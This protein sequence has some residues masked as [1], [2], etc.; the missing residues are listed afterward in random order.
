MPLTT[1]QEKDIR[2]FKGL[3]LFFV[4]TG[5][6]FLLYS[7]WFWDRG[8][9]QILP[10]VFAESINVPLDYIQL[11]LEIFPIQVEN[12]ILLQSYESLPPLSFP[13]LSLLWG[14]II[15]ILLVLIS[16]LLSTFK[17]TPFIISMGIWM[18]VLSISGINSLN[19]G[20]IYSNYALI[21][22]LVGWI[23][24]L[25]YIN[26]YQNHWTLIR[27]FSLTFATA[28]LTL[29][30][31]IYFSEMPAAALLIAENFTL[32]AVALSAIF[33]LHI[34]HAIFSG[35]T[36]LLLKLNKGVQLKITYH[37]VVLFVI[38]FLLVFS[39]LLDLLG[40]V[41]L[42]FP[43]VPPLLLF[44]MAG[45]IGFF[46]YR[47]KIEQTE[48]PFPIP[49]I[50]ESLY[51]TFFAIS[52]WTWG[53]AIFTENQPYIDFFDHIFLYGQVALSLLFFVYL[54]AN[55]TGVLNSGKDVEKIIFKPQH[56]AYFHM[57][58]GSVMALG[59]LAA[60]G[61][62][63]IINHI[64]S[65]STNQAADY[66]YQAE[67]PKQASILYESAWMQYRKNDKAKNAAVHLLLMDGNKRAVIE[68]LEQSMD[69]N[70]N[71]PNLLL[72]SK[73]LHER[74]KVFEAV[75]YLEKGLRLFPD[76]PYL[77]NNLA[78]LLSKLNRPADAINHLQSHVE[79][80][81]VFSANLM[82][83]KVKHQREDVDI[84]TTT[85]DPIFQ[86]NELA[87]ANRKGNLWEGTFSLSD[88]SSNF[89]IQ[90]A[91]IRN[92][93]TNQ[94]NQAIAR[95]IALIDSLIAATE[96]TFHERNLRDSRIIRLYQERDIAETLKYLVGNAGIFS[97]SAGYYH[98]WSAMVL[99]GQLD[100]EKAATDILVAE[101]R[102]VSDFK[103]H[104]LAILYF[105]NR[106][107]DAIRIHQKFNIPFPSWMSWGDDGKLE[108]N[109]QLQYFEAL[110][111]FHAKLEKELMQDLLKIEQSLL[112]ASFAMH[113]L[114]HKAHVL[115][116]SNIALIEEV[117]SKEPALP[118]SKQDVQKWIA[119]LKNKGSNLPDGNF[120]AQFLKP[121]LGLDRNP[122]WTPL[123]LKSVANA[124]D[125]MEGYNILQ[126]AKQFNKD[127]MLWIAYINQARKMGF[128]Q[129]A[130]DALQDMEAWLAKAEIEGLLADF[131]E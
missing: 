62:T 35:T 64:I 57:R 15:W 87:A 111:G 97:G 115:N 52:L 43:V 101:E 113:I 65:G 86:V 1:P 121:E 95:D 45:I 89:I 108:E 20:G 4:I 13:K 96:I 40:D 60:L 5:G 21:W 124:S 26:F 12:F 99:A 82:G 32:P 118:I 67:L 17:R 42:P 79:T 27:R 119:F 46:V 90:T 128:Q 73:L 123:I 8:I 125:D 59:I 48:Q 88:V 84:V 25:V 41:N 74:D 100:L 31:L 103:P 112:Q 105:G 39:S 109:P 70:P 49:Y 117:L 102:N 114:V 11:G 56:F 51:L 22:M 77:Q 24:P 106:P 129:Y 81:P 92:L 68:Q 28:T 9:F 98:Q 63:I 16:S 38:Y 130:N 75:F 69:F 72:L 18:A 30:G 104:H 47:E 23:V 33:L 61:D 50:G 93:W 37:L 116:T 107:I 19:I 55:F 3:P 94:P 91:A 54:L 36:I 127:P 76:N 2:F 58:I 71:V 131:I 29:L 44:F 83:L 34:G 122:Y 110:K 10:G 80:N 78:L 6:L 66:Y 53:K 7:L 126:D 120:F 85:H 14:T